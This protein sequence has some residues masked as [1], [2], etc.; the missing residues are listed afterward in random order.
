MALQFCIDL[1]NFV[2]WKGAILKKSFQRLMS[3]NRI[4]CKTEVLSTLKATRLKALLIMWGDVCTSKLRQ[5]WTE[6]GVVFLFN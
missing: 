5:F 4:T 1:L 6:N 3:Q 2:K